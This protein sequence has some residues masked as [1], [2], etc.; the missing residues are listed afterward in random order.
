MA[1]DLEHLVG[2]SLPDGEFTI[3]PR[4][5]H[6][7]AEAV[8]AATRLDDDMAHPIWAYIATQRGI[9]IRLDALFGLA[10]FAVEDGPM[11]GSMEVELIRPLHVAT[12]YRIT[13]EIIAIQRKRGRSIGSFDVLSVRE[14]VLDS[15]G[16]VVAVVTNS[17][18]LP[19]KAT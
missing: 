11:L 15:S 17:F 6:L 19:R 1:A 3:S 4:D 16:N 7:L 13:G 10:M 9:G 2:R 14:R 12:R 5:N 18:I 8:G